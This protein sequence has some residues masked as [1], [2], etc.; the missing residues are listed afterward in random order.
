LLIASLSQKEPVV[1]MP[2]CS[3]TQEQPVTCYPW[4]NACLLA[5]LFSDF[6]A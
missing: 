3:G 1:Q 4:S 6:H 5:S 2:N